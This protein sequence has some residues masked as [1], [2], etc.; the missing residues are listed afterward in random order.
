MTEILKFQ[1]DEP[2]PEDEQITV[3]F[4]FGVSLELV[5]CTKILPFFSNSPKQ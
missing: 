4:T 3:V 1:V 2:G 5:H